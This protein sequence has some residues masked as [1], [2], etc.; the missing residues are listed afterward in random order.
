MKRI[1]LGLIPVMCILL[2]GLSFSS[3]LAGDFSFIGINWNDDLDT[4]RKKINESG[5]PSDSR[6]TGLERIHTLKLHP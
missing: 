5:L 3:L 1:S 4:V 6:F 2:V